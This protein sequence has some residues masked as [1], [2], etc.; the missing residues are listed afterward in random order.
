MSEPLAQKEFSF[1]GVIF[2]YPGRDKWSHLVAENIELLHEAAKRLGLKPS[3]FQPKPNRPHY[4]IKGGK[5]TRAKALG[6][7]QVSGR[8]L[9]RFMQKHYPVVKSTE[10]EED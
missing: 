3:W 6:I 8:E 10:S 4:D 1:E 5:I 7:K 2:D 9:V